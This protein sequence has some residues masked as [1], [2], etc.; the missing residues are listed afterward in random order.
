MDFRPVDGFVLFM[1]NLN[2]ILIKLSLLMPID[3]V[4]EMLIKFFILYKYQ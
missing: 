1:T 3:E 4:I 2:S